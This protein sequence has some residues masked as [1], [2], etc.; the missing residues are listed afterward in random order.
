[1]PVNFVNPYTGKDNQT[2]SVSFDAQNQ[3]AGSVSS[4]QSE[5]QYNTSQQ[6]G[7]WGVITAKLKKKEI[8]DGTK[9][10]TYSQPGVGSRGF[11]Y[12][13][14]GE[15]WERKYNAQ[16]KQT[17]LKTY[18]TAK[19]E[20]YIQ[21]KYI[22]TA[23]PQAAGTGQKTADTTVTK[24]TDA[25]PAM[26]AAID[27]FGVDNVAYNAVT[28]QPVI[29]TNLNKLG[30]LKP[31][32]EFVYHGSTKKDYLHTGIHVKVESYPGYEND[33]A[34]VQFID[35]ST[36]KY[37]S[38]QAS[39]GAKWWIEKLQPE[40]GLSNPVAHAVPSPAVP[41]GSTSKGSMSH[42]DVAAMFVKVKDD[43]AKEQGLNIKGANPQLDALVY[44]KLGEATGYTPAEVKAKIDAY[45][46]DGN[47]LSA[48]KKKVMAGKVQV[49]STK[50]QDTKATPAAKLNTPTATNT[51]VQDPQPNGVPTV[52]TPNV[53]NEVKKQVQQTVSV[54]PAQHYSD[55]D[56]A[57]QY[58]IAKDKVVA[59]SNG[60]W[61]LYSKSDELDLE[62]AIQVG[63]KTGL[64]PTQQKQA[65]ANYLGSGKKLSVL[66]KQLIKQGAMKAQADTLK[67]KKAQ[68]NTHKQS[69]VNA[70]AEAGYTPTPT[71]SAG[72]PPT[73]TG[74]AAPQRVQKEAQQAGDISGISDATK[75]TIFTSFKSTGYKSY[76][77]SGPASNYDG[78]AEAQAKL[79]ASTGKK[80][81]LLQVIR[82]VDEQGAQKAGVAN[83]KLFEK[84][85]ATW[86]TTPAGTQHIKSKEAE[87]ATL[88]EQAKKKAE[89]EAAVKF[90]EGNQP[91]LPAD[92]GQFEEWSTSKAV[93]ISNQWLAAQPLTAKQKA[94]LRHYTGRA[95][96]QMNQYLRSG[97]TSSISQTSKN[98]IQGAKDGMR[99][100]TEPI[101]V[102]R[103]TGAN[104]F[105]TLGAGRGD[106]SLLW[107]LTGKTFKDKGF[108]STSA[109]G[110][111]AFGGECLLEIECPTGTPMM[112]VDPFSKHP[113]ENEMLL[114]AGLEYKI[115]QVR[116][117][118]NTFV[119]RA[120]VVNW[121]GKK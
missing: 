13:K 19:G 10:L 40:D 49:G 74:K 55:E 100:T 75:Q 44:A 15:L 113:G 28:K 98:H 94:G 67:S 63:L 92:S 61:T 77:S 109:G 90:V 101:L 81:T 86:L 11:L 47:K 84:Q 51:P 112:Y 65:L 12:V 5:A 117:E 83:G 91:P 56:I 121:P 72:T 82:V 118:G 35:V 85:V 42:E 69:D 25:S 4:P 27:Q 52:A 111:A 29:W 24:K 62:I 34:V 99:P 88:A 17:D 97:G 41:A 105:I 107:G 45:K 115:L 106:A 59:E 6:L 58:I 108:L 80:Y 78:L 110:Q 32:S 43:L 103:G 2:C 3:M 16:G 53:A 114:Q 8:P 119:V 57:A 102:K 104:Q 30:V 46:A 37:V 93:R 26:Q 89:A 79:E 33:P 36:G 38:N 50:P 14:N 73:D 1:M 31:G 71:P 96:A 48:L 39:N 64:N 76:L 87:L 20:A 18:G 22:D 21:S 23:I 9:L 54:Q 68:P 70:K 95:Y 120:R 7:E 116:K 60:K 66:K